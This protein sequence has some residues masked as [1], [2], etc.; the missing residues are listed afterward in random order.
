MS[1]SVSMLLLFFVRPGGQEPP[2]G[3]DFML[4]ELSGDFM[5]TEVGNYR[6]ITE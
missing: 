5:E 6:M 1:Q 2:P 3:S 4:T